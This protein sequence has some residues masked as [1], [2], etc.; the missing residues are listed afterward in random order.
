[1]GKK[2]PFVRIE[3]IDREEIPAVIYGLK[4]TEVVLTDVLE[5][6]HEFDMAIL[7]RPA[8][9]SSRSPYREAPDGSR[10]RRCPKCPRV[11]EAG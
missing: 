7:P 1:M 8:K 6:G 4:C 10:L 9:L 2:A 5:C 11:M 3:R